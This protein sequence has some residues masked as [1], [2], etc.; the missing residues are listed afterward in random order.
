[1]TSSKSS[2]RGSAH[3]ILIIALVAALIGV[4]GWVAWQNFMP[5]DKTVTSTAQSNT[6]NESATKTLDVT[7]WG[8]QLPLSKDI[9]DLTYKYEASGNTST[10]TFKS[11]RLPNCDYGSTGYIVRGS[12]GT[13]YYSA[14]DGT[15]VSFN[16]SDHKAGNY[17]YVYM[18]PQA[19]CSSES[20]TAGMDLESSIVQAL[21]EATAAITAS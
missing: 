8:A 2:E 9:E 17:Y 11:P 18:S 14:P 19:P 12:E 3:V 1:M 6:K 21:K 5:K 7:E 10:I 20:D 16:K 4:L 15:D 13:V